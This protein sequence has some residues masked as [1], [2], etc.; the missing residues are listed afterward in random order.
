MQGIDSL[1]LGPFDGFCIFDKE[2]QDV[3]RNGLG[4][5]VYSSKEEAITCYIL[6]FFIEDAEPVKGSKIQAVNTLHQNP[7]GR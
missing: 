5:C 6:S 3:A 4:L 1:D 7:K 2:R